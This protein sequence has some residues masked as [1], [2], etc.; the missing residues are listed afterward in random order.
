MAIFGGLPGAEDKGPAS[1]GAK[2]DDWDGRNG[3]GGLDGSS[4]FCKAG[5]W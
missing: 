1:G 4:G 5:V 3:G 2:G